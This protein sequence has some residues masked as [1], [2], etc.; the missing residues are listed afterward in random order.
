MPIGKKI[1]LYWDCFNGYSDEF[2]Y[3]AYDYV[4]YIK[5]G[6]PFLNT[7]ISDAEIRIKQRAEAVSSFEGK[8]GEA[9]YYV[10]SC[11]L[12]TSDAADE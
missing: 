12:Y 3:E 4:V 9:E 2:D 8:F 5:H 1:T 10:S 11:L 6:S 7:D